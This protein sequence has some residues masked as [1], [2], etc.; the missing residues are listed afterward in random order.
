[1]TP[2]PKF[3]AALVE[4]VYNQLV[5]LGEDLESFARHGN[6]K[7]ITP[8]DLFLVTRK[9]DDLTTLLKE[10]LFEMN[11]DDLGERKNRRAER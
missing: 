1:V 5:S 4:L 6:R 9:N 2:T 10:Y 8:D 7:T 3:I 11:S